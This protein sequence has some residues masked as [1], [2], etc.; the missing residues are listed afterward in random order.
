[1]KKSIFLLLAAF[2]LLL[3]GCTRTFQGIKEDTSSAWYGT[4]QVIHEA[5]SDEPTPATTP[6]T[7]DYGTEVTQ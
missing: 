2:V 7:T 5:T 1:M 6:A 4:K 3:S